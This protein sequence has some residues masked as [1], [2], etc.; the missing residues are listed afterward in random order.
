ME[1]ITT[2]IIAVVA[3]IIF[4]L[5]IREIVTWYWKINKITSQLE[6]ITHLLGLLVVYQAEGR[7]P[8]DTSITHIREALQSVERSVQNSK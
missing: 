7:K 4:F 6:D 5:I 3:A 1:S 8:K 2:I